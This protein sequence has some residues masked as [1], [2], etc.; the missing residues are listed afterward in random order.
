[1]NAA[2]HLAQALL[3]DFDFDWASTAR[4]EQLPPTDPDWLTWLILAGRGFGK[5]RTGAET[6]RAWVTGSSPLG[7]ARYGRV[8][9]VAETASDARDVMVEGESG[10]LAI[11]PPGFRPVYEPSKRRLTWPNG[12]IA[13]LYNATEPDQLRGPQ[14]DS[15]WADEM[16]KW[17]Y[18]Q[19]T[20]DQ[21]SFGLRLGKKPRKVVTTT[22]RP[23][24]VLK[25]IIAD[26]STRVT[27]GKTL[28]NAANLAPGF[29][30]SITR[31][32]EGTRLGRQELDAELLTDTPGALFAVSDIDAARIKPDELPE[33]KRVVVAIDP[34]VSTRENSDETGI[35]VAG[36]DHKGDGYVL[37]DLS[38]KL[39]PEAWARKAVE[40]YQFWKAD[41][42]IAEVNNG[43]DLVEATLRMVSRNV[44]YKAVHASRGKAIRA[45]PVAALYEQRRVHH[46]GM[47][48]Q[49]E[50]QMSSFTPDFDRNRAGYSPDRLDA[51]V[52]ALSELMVQPQGA[53]RIISW[54]QMCVESRQIVDE[55]AYRRQFGPR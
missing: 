45:E 13:T 6:I 33:M 50:D 1:M 37:A 26:P 27:R 15:A 28:D 25:E 18:A 40:A 52:W 7:K 19:D 17:A 5:T 31:R 10:I 22:P 8:A 49:L 35:V 41:R 2:A 48:S 32:Y 51:A 34:A 36:L 46:V 30:A 29:V 3:D 53:S 12:A 11:S 44:S 42:I 24:K 21:L 9:L 20:W 16:A 43:G 39:S 47:F 4:P 14:H 55:Q 23:I 54:H 38:A